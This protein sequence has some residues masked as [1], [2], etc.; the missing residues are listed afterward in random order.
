MNSYDQDLKSLEIRVIDLE[1]RVKIIEDDK[2]PKKISKALNII[3]RI[4][5]I[6]SLFKK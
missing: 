6:Y 4:A 2:P 3:K 5:S 1:T